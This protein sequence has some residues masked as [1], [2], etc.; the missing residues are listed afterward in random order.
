V[1]FR[2]ERVKLSA[3]FLGALEPST[4]GNLELTTSKVSFQGSHCFGQR[5]GPL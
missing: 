1:D 4:E 2:V 3:L 5:R